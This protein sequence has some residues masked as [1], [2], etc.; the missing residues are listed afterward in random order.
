MEITEITPDMFP[1]YTIETLVV[2]T[3]EWRIFTVSPFNSV[4]T[5]SYHVDLILKEYPSTNKDHIRVAK[6]TQDMWREDMIAAIKKDDDCVN[7]AL[8]ILRS[9]T[10]LQILK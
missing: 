7:R 3:G 10:L 8:S 9:E 5:A 4:V 6:Y 2:K 1:L